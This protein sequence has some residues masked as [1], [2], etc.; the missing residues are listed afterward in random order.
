MSRTNTKTGP[1]GSV[2]ATDKSSGSACPTTNFQRVGA[3][4]PWS[5]LQLHALWW[6]RPTPL[7]LQ[8]AHAMK[9]PLA[10]APTMALTTTAPMFATMT[11]TRST[12]SAELRYPRS[13]LGS[14]AYLPLYTE[15]SVINLLLPVRLVYL[16]CVAGQ[17]R[18]FEKFPQCGHSRQDALLFVPNVIASVLSLHM[19]TRAFRTLI[20]N[21]AVAMHRP[22][23][24]IPIVQTSRSGE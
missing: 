15:Q 19:R 4:A 11:A 24:Q 17:E 7:Q 3:T 22:V 9:A 6:T 2:R 10:R 13:R 8:Q 5:R 14:F 20:K 16:D 21:Q 23:L 12:L 18:S 1:R